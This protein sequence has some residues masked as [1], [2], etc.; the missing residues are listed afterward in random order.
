MQVSRNL[1]VDARIAKDSFRVTAQFFRKVSSFP[2]SKII[3]L[4][5]YYYI[6]AIIIIPSLYLI[7]KCPILIEGLYVLK[8]R[9]F[10]GER[11][12]CFSIFHR[13]RDDDRRMNRRV[14][15]YT[16]RLR[17]NRRRSC[18]VKTNSLLETGRWD[19]VADLHGTRFVERLKKVEED[20][21]TVRGAPVC[22]ASAFGWSFVRDS[23][24]FLPAGESYR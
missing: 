22:Y 2:I 5:Y 8:W 3:L 19:F 23:C 12:R 6:F 18:G 21:E 15:T 10:R 4:F 24:N 16:G 7:L 20:G 9:V 13:T 17:N 11:V 14:S 1:E